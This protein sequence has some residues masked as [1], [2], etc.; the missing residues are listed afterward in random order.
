M[1]VGIQQDGQPFQLPEAT[2][3]CPMCQR[4]QTGNGS[5]FCLDLVRRLSVIVLKWFFAGGQQGY[6]R[7]DCRPAQV[8]RSAVAAA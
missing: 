7:A 6:M 1:C 2:T 8:R 3:R 4:I 5:I